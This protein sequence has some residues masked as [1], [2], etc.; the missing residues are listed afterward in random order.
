MPVFYAVQRPADHGPGNDRKD[1][2]DHHEPH[3]GPAALAFRIGGK[4]PDDRSPEQGLKIRV[5]APE[6]QRRDESIDQT[7]QQVH[8]PGPKRGQ[9][10]DD[11]GTPA[12][13]E[14]SVDKLSG[15]VDQRLKAAEDA[16]CCKLVPNPSAIL[17]TAAE[18][19]ILQRYT[20]PYVSTHKTA[21]YTPR[22]C[23]FISPIFCKIKRVNE[24]RSH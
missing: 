19:L 17:S 3:Q 6:D 13:D 16:D 9:P 15:G 2:N 18:M 5:D 22:E 24:K 20:V 10:D 21:R 11:T 14:I 4:R 7:H 1:R 8:Q 23:L 12:V